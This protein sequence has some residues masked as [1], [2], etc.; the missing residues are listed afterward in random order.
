MKSAVRRM[1]VCTLVH[2]ISID[3][4]VYNMN[5]AESMIMKTSFDETCGSRTTGSILEEIICP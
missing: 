4:L 5:C 3:L 1:M 2:R